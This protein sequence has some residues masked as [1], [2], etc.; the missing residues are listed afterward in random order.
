[1]EKLV[2][3]LSNLAVY[4]CCLPLLLVYML[5]CPPQASIKLQYVAREEDVLDGLTP[6][7]RT[8]M[9]DKKSY[10]NGGPTAIHAFSLC[11]G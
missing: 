5:S 9:S 10:Q 7:V 6:E 8:R 11:R 2:H 4:S 3:M 1:M